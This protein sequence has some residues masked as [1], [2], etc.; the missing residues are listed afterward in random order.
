MAGKS[1]KAAAA[2]QQGEVALILAA[3]RLFA[4]QGI[5]AV[6]LRH[7]NSAANQ[8]NMSAAHYHFGSRDGLVEAVLM[9]RLPGLDQR[10]GALIAGEGGARDLDF[11]LNAFVRPLIQELMPRDE[12]NHY[13]RYMQQCERWRGDYE[14]VR[15][16]TPASVAIYDEL[17]RLISY[18]PDDVRRLRIGYLINMIHSALAIAEERLSRAIVSH[19]EI[20]LI[21]A[22]LID[23][24]TSALTATLSSATMDLL[25]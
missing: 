21:A 14:L 11:Y 4:E 18:L 16:L 10:R 8:K 12:G 2:P 23:M 20:E 22:N 19:A 7:V 3:E 5:E 1:A 25:A 9:Y 15:S 6:A 24:S 13:I 17:E